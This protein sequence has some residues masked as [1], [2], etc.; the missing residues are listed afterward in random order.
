MLKLDT[1][2]KTRKKKELGQIETQ[3]DRQ[4]GT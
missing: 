4:T 1:I 2:Q 3:R